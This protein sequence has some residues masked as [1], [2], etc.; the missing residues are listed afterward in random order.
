MILVEI[1][2]DTVQIIN[3]VIF[4]TMTCS[5]ISRYAC[6]LVDTFY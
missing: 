5:G 1:Y 2:I 6:V 4:K 3:E